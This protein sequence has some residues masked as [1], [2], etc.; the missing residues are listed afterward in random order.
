MVTMTNI[1]STYMPLNLDSL[2]KLYNCYFNEVR[3]PFT[4]LF[5]VFRALAYICVYIFS[6]LQKGKI[7]CMQLM[8][9]LQ[10]Q[11]AQ[12]IDSKINKMVV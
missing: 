7:A 10:C 4:L 8:N 12:D 1:F 3:I 9:K 11:V 2:N 6:V 5:K